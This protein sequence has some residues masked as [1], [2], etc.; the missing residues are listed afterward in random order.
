MELK[1][2]RF[3]DMNKNFEAVKGK[4]GQYSDSSCCITCMK[5][6]IFV[7]LHDGA[8]VD[9][10]LPVVYDGFLMTSSGRVLEVRDSKLKAKLGKTESAHGTLV[11]KK[12]N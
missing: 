12:W 9:L 5:N 6:I 3:D 4:W 1:I 11:L 7:N 8:D 2:I 10:V